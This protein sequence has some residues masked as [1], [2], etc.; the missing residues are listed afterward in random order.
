MGDEGTSAP[1]GWLA[2]FLHGYE[3]REIVLAQGI[4]FHES[5]YEH[6]KSQGYSVESVFDFLERKIGSDFQ[7]SSSS[8]G[9]YTSTQQ[10]VHFI[11]R[12]IQSKDDFKQALE[13]QNLHVVYDGHS[14]YGRGT[15]F[16]VYS[17]QYD[18]TG[19]Q[20]E[21]GSTNSNGIFRLG[22]PYIGIPLEDIEHH[23]YLF[24]PIPAE[25]N[26]PSRSERHPHA[27]RSLTRIHL[28]EDLR[29]Y[30]SSG[31]ESTGDRYWGY[32][33]HGKIHLLLHAGWENTRSD[34]FDLGAATLNCKVFCHFGCSSSL[35]YWRIVRTTPYKGWQRPSPPTDRFAYFTTNTADETGTFY[36]LYYILKYPQENNFQSW[37]RSLQWAKYKTNRKL[38]IERDIYRI[39]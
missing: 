2:R 8:R 13:T 15:C 31:F 28:P 12:I 3:T 10:K 20:W 5:D 35:H 38:R 11:I 29:G 1:S 26:P 23:E 22:Y 30:V 21:Q 14:R 9:E 36:W 19:D 24:A 17:G 37:W 4:Q 16:D 25:N 7:T 39:Y 27:R 34:P 18:G 33:R 32:R 6:Y